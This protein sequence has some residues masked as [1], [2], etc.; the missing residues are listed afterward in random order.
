MEKRN[1]Y[2]LNYNLSF[3]FVI[4]NPE[5]IEAISN[6]MIGVLKDLS[7]GGLS[8]SSEEDVEL[9]QLLEVKINDGKSLILVLGKIVRKQKLENHYLYG[10]EF[11]YIDEKTQ[12]KLVQFIFNVQRKEKV[13]KKLGGGTNGFE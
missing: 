12:D 2:R 10:L 3:D 1:F 9:D 11:V 6:P 7:G 13:M 4:L 5:S 8:F